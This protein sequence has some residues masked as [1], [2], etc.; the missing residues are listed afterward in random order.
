MPSWNLKWSIGI[1]SGPTPFDLR[2]AP[3]IRNPVL[4]AADVTDAE[5]SLV[6]D[7]FLLRRGATWHLFFEMLNAGTG[8]GEIAYATSEDGLRWAY[9]GVVLREPFHLSYPHVFEADGG[10]Y[11]VAETR[12]AG[13]VRLY[14]A[15]DFPRG[16]SL[17]GE[18]VRGPFADPTVVRHEGRWW[19]F[20]QRGLDELR[21]FSSAGLR[22]PWAEHP[23]S[24]LWPGNRVYSRPG[25]RMLRHEGGLYR[26]AQDGLLSYGHSLRALRVDRLDERE[27]EE[28]ELDCSP[29]LTATTSGWNASAMHHLDVQPD[30]GAA[31]GWIAAVDG[32]SAGY[33]QEEGDGRRA[34][35]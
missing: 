15:R 21:L 14:A 19:L 4:T 34:D 18:L 17:A 30:P 25:G 27:Y 1:Y 12:Q 28:H 23:K 8:L 13:A 5:A 2:P 31:G 9:G 20:A 29:I 22:G 24:P 3:G 26:F 11:M 33:N 6:A 16:W 35:G 10:V 32:A 7:P